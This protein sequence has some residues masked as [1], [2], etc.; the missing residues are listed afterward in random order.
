MR[1]PG[2]LRIAEKNDPSFASSDFLHIGQGFFEHSVIWRDDD[3]RHVF[4]D[5]RNGSMLEFPRGI[6]LGVNIG[7]FLE[8]E[9]PFERK[10]IAGAAAEIEHVS[11]FREIARQMLYLRLE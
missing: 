1:L 10:R 7:D 11:A 5:Q 8:L 9:G 2:S 4:V 3:H 6:A